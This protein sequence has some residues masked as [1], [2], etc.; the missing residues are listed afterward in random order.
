MRTL[1]VE[2]GAG[3]KMV[4]LTIPEDARVTFGPFSPP[5]AKQDRYAVGGNNI[6]TLRV[7]GPGTETKASILA[8]LS[9]VTGFR[10]M[11]L[12]DYEEEVA[13][14][15]GAVMWKSDKDGYKRE[16]KVKRSSEWVNPTALIDSPNFDDEEIPF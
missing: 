14:E 16:E 9:N 4:K 13:R 15:E 8:V 1:L 2:R 7:Y 12:V 5:S 3:G 11:S 6:G 10:D